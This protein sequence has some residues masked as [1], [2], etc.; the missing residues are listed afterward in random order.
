MFQLASPVDA[1]KLTLVMMV[2]AALLCASVGGA[3]W[4][5][6]RCDR[7]DYLDRAKPFL[8]N[9]R[10]QYLF[11]C[12]RVWRSVDGGQ[13]WARVLAQGLPFGLRD[14]QIGVDRKPGLLYL[15][16]L[17]RPRLSPNFN[18]LQCAWVKVRPTIY[19]SYDGGARWRLGHTFQPGSVGNT[20][21]VAVHA[22][23]DY[24]S[25]AWVILQHGDEVAYYGT[26]TAGHLWQKTCVEDNL[27]SPRCDPP[28]DLLRFRHD[29]LHGKSGEDP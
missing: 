13:T 19:I 14:A 17:T 27:A 28:D 18:C 15:G 3:A 29:K 26:N 4:R 6:T 1:R 16:A 9:P 23:P 8:P 12:G 5:L 2:G 21:F 11:A 24:E 7:A 22:D 10:E 20:R 25:A